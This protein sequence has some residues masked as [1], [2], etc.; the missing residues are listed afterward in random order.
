MVFRR[1]QRSLARSLV[2]GIPWAIDEVKSSHLWFFP[3]I[4]LRA[5]LLFIEQYWGAAKLRYRDSPKTTDINEIEANILY[6]KALKM[7]HLFR[8]KG[9]LH[10]LFTL[11]SLIFHLSQ[12]RYAN[13]SAR[14]YQCICTLRTDCHLGKSKASRTLHTPPEILTKLK[15]EF[16][17]KYGQ[18]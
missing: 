1:S 17:K 12:V 2:K 11:T 8:F 10:C 13:W 4:P 15:Y 7:S 18:D 14:F 16:H 5:Q 9:V 6:E 3:E